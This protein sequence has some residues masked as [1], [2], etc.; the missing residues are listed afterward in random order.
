LQVFE[1][2][3]SGEGDLHTALH[4]QTGNRRL[5]WH[6]TDVSAAAAICSTGLRIMPGAGGRLGSL[7]SFQQN[8]ALE[9]S[10]WIARLLLV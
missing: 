7:L 5:L 9:E 1:L 6:G 3:R 10:Y 2:N 4:A 8:A